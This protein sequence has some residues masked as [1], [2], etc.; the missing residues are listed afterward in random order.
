MKYDQGDYN[1]LRNKAAST[2]W[3]SLEDNDINTYAKNVTDYILSVSKLCIPK[4][5]YKS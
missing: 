4:K 2:D 1:L 5:K 3:E